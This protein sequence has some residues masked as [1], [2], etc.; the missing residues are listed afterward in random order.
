[1]RRTLLIESE[2]GIPAAVDGEWLLRMLK[3]GELNS[4]D[5]ETRVCLWDRPG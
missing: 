4:G 1:M 2:H 5:I 3:D